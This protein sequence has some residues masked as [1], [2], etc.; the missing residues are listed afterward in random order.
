MTEE[1]LTSWSKVWSTYGLDVHPILVQTLDS[2][3]HALRHLVTVIHWKQQVRGASLL[4]QL[5]GPRDHS[6]P[7]WTWSSSTVSS[8]ADPSTQLHIPFVSPLFSSVSQCDMQSLGI[9]VYMV[10]VHCFIHCQTQ[11]LNLCH[12]Q[13][14]FHQN[15]TWQLQQTIVCDV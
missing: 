5:N 3:Q 12:L 2:Q 8:S 11:S 13:N 15:N 7:I 1:I 6:D 4:Q 10:A 9:G 14:C